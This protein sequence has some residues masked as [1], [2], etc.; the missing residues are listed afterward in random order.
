[1]VFVHVAAGSF[2]SVAVAKDG[3]VWCWG[4]NAEGQCGGQGLPSLVFAPAQLSSASL[5]YTYAQNVSAAADH[6]FVTSA[7]VIFTRFIHALNVLSY[8][9]V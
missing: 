5:G 7:L 3:S 9:I 4:K 6:T 1:M 8:L 2:H